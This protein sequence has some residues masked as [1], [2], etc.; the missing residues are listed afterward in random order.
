MYFV[1]SPFHLDAIDIPLV[2]GEGK[3][4]K[5]MGFSANQRAAFLKRTMRYGVGTALSW[6]T[7]DRN[8]GFLRAK[9]VTHLQEYT[10]VFIS[11]ILEPEN[12]S[13]VYAGTSFSPSLLPLLI[14]FSPPFK[15]LMLTT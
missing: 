4:M 3:V 12:S 11:H 5:I 6:S 7:N 10:R 13:D 9:S 1:N 14:Y 8:L 2:E 15:P